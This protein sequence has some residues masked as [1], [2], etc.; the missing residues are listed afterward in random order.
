MV[1]T[2]GWYALQGNMTL[3]TKDIPVRGRRG[4]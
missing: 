2:K 1:T 4:P 3:I